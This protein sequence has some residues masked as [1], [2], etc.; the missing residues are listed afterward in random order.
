MS[1][2]VVHKYDAGGVILNVRGAAEARA[3]FAKIYENVGKAVPGAKIQG[4][5]VEQM[6]AKGVE[7]ILGPTAMRGLDR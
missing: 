5:L 7:V 6:A 2:D 4:I 1:E 3:A